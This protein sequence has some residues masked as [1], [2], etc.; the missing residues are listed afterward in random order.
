MLKAQR[1]GHLVNVASLAGLVHPAGMGSYNA[2]KA[3]VVA[4]TETCGHELAGYGIRASAVCP[5]YFRTNLMDSMQGSDTALGEVVRGPGRALPDHRRG[6]RRRRAG[7]H[8][9]RGRR[10]RARRAG[11]AGLLPQVGRPAGVRPGDA[12]QAAKLARPPMRDAVAGAKPVREEDAF[13]VAAVARLAARARRRHHRPRR[14]PRGP[15]VLRRGVQPD[16]PAALPRPG[17]DPAPGAGGH[18]GAGAHDMHREFVIQSALAPVF[19]YVAPMVAFCDDPSVIGADFY[20]MERI[21]GVIP[22]SEW[23]ADVPLSARAG[24]RAVPAAR[25]R[26]RRA[27]QRGRRRPPASPTSARAPATY[28]ARSRAGRCA[29]ATPAPT[30]SPTTRT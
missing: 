2:T 17:P 27:A 10:D 26:A 3:A 29:T 18:Q 28:D 19:A 4:F 30:T 16:L 23:P 6:D 13:D 11:P 8:G 14:H 12:R 5:S 25:R 21:D 9:R 20:A 7:R 1:S 15:P 22:R 24:A